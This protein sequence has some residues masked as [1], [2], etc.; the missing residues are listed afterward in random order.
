MVDS[1]QCVQCVASLRPEALPYHLYLIKTNE[2][3]F[4]FIPCKNNWTYSWPKSTKSTININKKKHMI[5]I[6]DQTNTIN[7]L[8]SIEY[9]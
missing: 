1:C 3:E 6:Y 5:L 7:K 2:A 9:K 8:Y 4:L